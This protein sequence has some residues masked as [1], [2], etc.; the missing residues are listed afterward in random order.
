MY[1]AVESA[2]CTY[3]ASREI[4][5]SMLLPAK[6]AEVHTYF[7]IKALVP[8]ILVCITAFVAIFINL[9]CLSPHIFRSR[10]LFPIS[11]SATTRYKTM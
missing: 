2:E 4:V 7:I 11:H 9:N 6:R 8:M 1:N 3:A 10:R 5:Q